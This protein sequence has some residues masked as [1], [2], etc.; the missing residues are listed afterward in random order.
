MLLFPT[1]WWQDTDTFGHVADADEEPGWCY[2]WYCFPGLAGGPLLA[3]LISGRAALEVEAMSDRAVTD[4]VLAQLRRHHPER[5]VPNPIAAE[6]ARW[7][8]DR[9]TLGAYSSVPP[10]CEGAADYDELARNLGG[11]LFFAGEA[12]TSR[13]PAQM[14]GA[15]DSGLREVRRSCAP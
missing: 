3:A 7:G 13:Y 11:C 15:Y 9:N 5:D 10:G 12:T 1:K 4:R 14:H 2:L 6:I 8:R